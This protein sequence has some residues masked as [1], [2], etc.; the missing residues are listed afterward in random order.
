[1]MICCPKIGGM[2]NYYPKISWIL[3]TKQSF[4][5]SSSPP[6]LATA[7]KDA[8]ECSAALWNTIQHCVSDCNQER[9]A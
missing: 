9:R 7:H 5:F 2:T 1:M 3:A 8:P 6:T 4:P